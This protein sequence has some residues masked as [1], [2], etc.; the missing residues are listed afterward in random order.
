MKKAYSGFKSALFAWQIANEISM[1][2]INSHE[3]SLSF[4]SFKNL[5]DNINMMI[6]RDREFL[7]RSAIFMD[8]YST[9]DQTLSEFNSVHINE[10]RSHVRPS[11][12]CLAYHLSKKHNI[13]K[14][15]QGFRAMMLLS[16]RAEKD[17]HKFPSYHN[18]NHFT[19][20]VAITSTL[21]ELNDGLRSKIYSPIRKRQSSD[22]S[23]SIWTRH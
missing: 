8:K 23:P 20:V 11:L 5:K 14:Y 19:D 3:L 7:A 16:I 22:A 17:M 21:L 13:S 2:A 4:G 15:S 1:C 6:K 9:A 10:Y 12:P 18:R